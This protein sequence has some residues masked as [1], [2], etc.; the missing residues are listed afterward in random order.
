MKRECPLWPYRPEELVF[1]TETQCRCG[2]PFASVAVGWLTLTACSSVLT[3]AAEEHADSHYL[4]AKSA[5]PFDMPSDDAREMS[6][7]ADLELATSAPW[8]LLSKHQVLAGRR[9]LVRRLIR[10]SIN[11]EPPRFH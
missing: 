5:L 1:K 7:W 6:P 4:Q 8:G 2:A 10:Q 3:G 11:R 9:P